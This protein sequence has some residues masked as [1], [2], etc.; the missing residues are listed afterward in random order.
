MLKILIQS[1]EGKKIKSSLLPNLQT[2]S[3]KHSP[4]LSSQ[5]SVHMTVNKNML[6]QINFLFQK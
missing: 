6:I 2:L 4:A 1:K 5:G 3:L